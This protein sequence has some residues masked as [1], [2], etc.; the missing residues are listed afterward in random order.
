MLP[1]RSATIAFSTLILA[2]QLATAQTGDAR[3]A[4]DVPYLPTTDEAVQAMLKLAEVKSS[5]VVYDLG[6]GDGRIVIAAAKTYGAHGVGIDINP[7]RIREAN[8][9]AHKAGVEKLVRFE[10]SDLFKADIHEATVVAL[11]LLNT[12][13]LSLRP[14]LLRDL[15]PGT[16]IV[17]NTFKMGD[18]E[19]VREETVESTDMTPFSRKI[20][21]WIV[22]ARDRK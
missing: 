14:K 3:R 15:K 16:R 20:Y 5:D 4:P 19:P 11:F 17:S 18:W 21:L 22:P 13:N 2:A 8:E 6:C 9:N 7:D 12:V 1:A 10:E